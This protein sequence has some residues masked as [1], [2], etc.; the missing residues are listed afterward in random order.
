MYIAL[1]IFSAMFLGIG[2]CVI[3][4]MTRSVVYSPADLDA[5][6]GVL[7]LATVP[8]QAARLRGERL[9]EPE[10]ANPNLQK[11][12]PTGVRASAKEIRT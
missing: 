8:M 4:E 7:T 6:S 11:F 1:G 12:A 5:V 10:A 2:S 9:A 3:G